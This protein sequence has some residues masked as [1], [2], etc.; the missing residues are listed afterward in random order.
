MDQLLMG[1]GV[2]FDLDGTLIDTAGDLA[3]SMNHVLCENGR[4][5]LAPETVRHLVGFGAKRMLADGFGLDGGETMDPAEMDSHVSMFLEHYT[6]NIAVS[7]RP[8]DGVM[9]AVET[10]RKSGARVA[11][12]TN[13]REMLARQLIGELGLSDIFTVIVGADTSTAAKPDP[14][15]VRFCMEEL[16]VERAVFFGDSD[17]DIRASSAAGLPCLVHMK[18]YGPFDLRDRAFALFDAYAETPELVKTS[19]GVNSSL[20]WRCSRQSGAASR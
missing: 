18:G 13:K 7:S 2:I 17:T 6:A 14:A 16:A 15:P 5:A 11:I 20:S 8:F 10:L 3:A 9:D 4:E 19:A 12:C 1:V